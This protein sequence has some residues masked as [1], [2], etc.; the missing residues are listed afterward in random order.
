MRPVFIA[1]NVA[2]TGYSRIVKDQH[3]KFVVKKDNIII[4]GIGFNLSNKFYLLQMKK[5]LDMVFTLDENE[6]NGERSLQLKVID[7][8]LSEMY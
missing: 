6:W 5:T 3:V 4:T 2:D 1:K 7:L 8:R